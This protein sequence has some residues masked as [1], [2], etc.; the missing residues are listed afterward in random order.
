MSTPPGRLTDKHIFVGH[1]RNDPQMPHDLLGR[2]G[3][4]LMKDSGAL[5]H[6]NKYDGGHE[7]TKPALA[8]LNAWLNGI[9]AP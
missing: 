9:T 3:D 1:S 7:I 2:A 4:Y 6:A 5:A 8:D